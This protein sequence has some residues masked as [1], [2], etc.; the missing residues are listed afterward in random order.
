MNDAVIDQLRTALSGRYAIE[1]EL[2]RG[3]MATVFLAQDLHHHRKVAI[4]VLHPELAAAIGPERFLREIDTL[5]GLTHPHIVPL[6]DSGQ[7]AGLVYFAMPYVEGESLRQ[8]L[9]REKQLPVADAVRITAEIADAIDYAHEHGIVHRDLKPENVLLQHGRAM[10]ADFGVARALAAAGDEKLTR[11]GFTVG[12][13]PYMSPEQIAGGAVDARSDVYGLGCVVYEMLAGQAPFTGPT[14]ESVTYQ[15]LNAPPPEVTQLRPSAGASVSAALLRALAKTPADRFATAGAVAEALRAATAVSAQPQPRSAEEPVAKRRK[16]RTRPL[17]LAAALVIVAL[18]A[19]AAW[20]RWGPF[21]G[22]FGGTSLHH[23]A[24]KDWI[25]VAEF[26][27]PPGDSTLAPAARSLVSA[28]LDESEILATVPRDQI[29]LALRQAG[30]PAGTRVNGEVARELAYRSAVRAVLEADIERIGQ[31]YSVV[32]RVVDA[33]SLKTV[34]TERAV[35]KNENALIPA[36]GRLAEELRRGLGERRSAIAATR[37]ITAVAT[38]SFEAYQL[39][40]QAGRRVGSYSNQSA[41]LLYRQALVLDP[42]FAGAWD[43]LAAAYWNLGKMDSCVA[44]E[45]EALRRPQRLTFTHRLITEASRAADGGDVRG[46]LAAYNR[47]LRDN[48]THRGAL[49]HSA[50]M[51]TRLGRFREALE[52]FRQIEAASPFGVSDVLLGNQIY[53]LICLGSFDEARRV[54]LRLSVPNR[55]GWQAPIEFAAANWEAAECLSTAL[56]EDPR[57]QGTEDNVRAIVYLASIQAV[58]GFLRTAAAT[59]E[60]AQNAAHVSESRTTYENYVRRG[61]L[62]LTLA[63]DGVVKA[64]ADD[65]APDS[66]TATLLSRGLVAA[67]AG[68]RVAAQRWLDAARARPSLEI[69]W[70]GATPQLLAAR[71]AALTGRWDEAARLLRPVT[72]QPVEIGMTIYPAGMTMVRWSLADAYEKLGHPDSAAI[73]LERVVSD[74][75]P[76]REDNVHGVALPFAH[77]R[78]VLLYA[79]LGRVAD[80]ER[81][82]AVVEKWFTTPDPEARRLLDEARSAVRA[83]RGMARP[84]GRRT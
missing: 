34:L 76:P 39:Y 52:A 53:E 21:S 13:P 40:I 31:G 51:L 17:A 74:P 65:W 9:E 45:N 47:I 59:F 61:R 44:A 22:W 1:R 38:P 73:C 27:G 57:T 30:K 18:V 64:P 80:A 55:I 7:A 20:Q 81:H 37:P 77:L 56:A 82:L 4:K 41:V 10:L 75:A 19:V 62:M 16:R 72:S 15:H 63:S 54:A 8:R 33:E 50:I 14:A 66:S 35:A 69:A 70:Q 25:L 3:G 26:D 48:P 24:K 5:A 2:G 84:E 78:L 71:I 43:A 11:T 83:A 23:P 68:D 29:Q 32:L 6:F 67:I 60:R 49:S 28:A 36:L 46:A 42:D 58:R 12:T 79:R